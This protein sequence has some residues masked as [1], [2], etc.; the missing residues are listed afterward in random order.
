MT[1]RLGVEDNESPFLLEA[2]QPGPSA[3]DLIGQL[4]L[5]AR[6]L[7]RAGRRHVERALVRQLADSGERDP[8]AMAGAVTSLR[9][10]VSDPGGDEAEALEVVEEELSP[11]MTGEES[12]CQCGHCHESEESPEE[13]EAETDEADELEEADELDEAEEGYETDEEEESLEADAA[14]EADEA[15][16]ADEAPLEW[17]VEPSFEEE[18]DA[19]N[20]AFEDEESPFLAGEGPEEQLQAP[21]D[22]TPLA[23]SVALEPHLAA[24]KGELFSVATTTGSKKTAVFVP[25]AVPKTG[26]ITALVWIHGDLIC[27]DRPDALSHVQSEMISLV[28]TLADSKRAFVLIAPSMGWTAK[29]ASHALGTPATMNAF[30]DQVR[31]SLVGAGWASA[32]TIDRLIL[33]GHSHAFAVFYGLADTA[34][35]PDSWKD[36][37]AKLTDVWWL[38]ATYGKDHPNTFSRKLTF[39]AAYKRDV[40]FSVLY[41]PGSDTAKVAERVEQKA[42]A[43]P[44]KIDIR[45]LPR[46]ADKDTSDHCLMPQRQMGALLA[47]AK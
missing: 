36:A 2:L 16:E 44:V 12:E 11:P 7:S 24:V 25:A 46:D 15:D 28:K 35:Q 1:S 20:E 23:K 33:A 37:L 14:S 42:K 6:R 13:A 34:D 5:V 10:A 39:W 18:A 27:R 3:P 9:R 30:L 19:G 40:K 8:R 38:D 32:P 45:A 22:K 29:Q 47:A 43:G 4:S 17:E 31:K 21:G 26:G 41:I